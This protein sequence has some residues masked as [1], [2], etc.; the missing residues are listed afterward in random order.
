MNTANDDNKANQGK[1][2][3]LAPIILLIVIVVI[4]GAIWTVTDGGSYRGYAIEPTGTP[5]TEDTPIRLSTHLQV[6]S[7]GEWYEAIV[8]KLNKDGTF[9][10]HFD[11][12]ESRFDEDVPRSRMRLAPV[13]KVTP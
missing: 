11:G 9:K 2:K 1:K 8:L 12:W 5:V 4:G 13:P 7:Q 10:V 6:K 3:K